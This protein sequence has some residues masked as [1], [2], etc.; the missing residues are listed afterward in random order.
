MV[1]A[2]YHH[3][4]DAPPQLQLPVPVLRG[5]QRVLGGEAVPLLAWVGAPPG[6]A[7]ANAHTSQGLP[8]A[9]EA[10]TGRVGGGVEVSGQDTCR[11]SRPSAISSIVRAAMT[12]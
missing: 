6:V 8:P 11:P 4:V 3:V 12:V 5:D 1:A 10:H 2:T 7:V 9:P